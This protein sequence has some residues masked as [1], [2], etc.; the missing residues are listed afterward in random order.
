MNF[1]R[2]AADGVTIMVK[3]QPRARRAGILGRVAS[4]SG[5]RLKIAVTEPAEDGEA[6]RAVGDLLAESLDRPRSAVRILSGGS[7]REKVLAVSGDPGQLAGKLS[8]L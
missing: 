5:T 8:T 7:N 3:V 4:A 1:W 2:E 6:N